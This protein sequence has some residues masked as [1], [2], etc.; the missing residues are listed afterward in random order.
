[1]AYTP[2][3]LL[4]RA[5][6]FQNEPAGAEQGIAE[7]EGEADQESEGGH[8]VEGSASEMPSVN[9]ETLNECT[10]HDALGKGRQCRTVTERAVPEAS[11]GGPPEPELEGDAAE[12]Q[13]QQHDEDREV[14]RRNDDGE[15]E[16][17]CGQQAEAAEHHPGFIAVPDRR[18]RVHD[19]VAPRFVVRREAVKHS[20]PEIEPIEDHVIE[21]RQSQE[22]GPE[23]NKIEYH[24]DNP[25][26]C[27]GVDRATFSNGRSGRPL[28]TA[29]GT[30]V[31]S[32]GPRRTSPAMN[33]M[34]VGNMMR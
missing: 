7:Y 15:G 30:R 29:N 16:R 31:Q 32:C 21:D 6:G 4:Q 19:E 25:R 1:M 5:L 20:D 23:R 2:R 3:P 13:R 22:G 18:H 27:S 28:S 24:R 17:K 12:H 9:L 34:P 33:A 10:E 8:P 11:Q 26:Y 14:N